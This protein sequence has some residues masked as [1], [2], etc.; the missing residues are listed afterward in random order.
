MNKRSAV[1]ITNPTA[2]GGGVRRQRTVERFCSLMNARGV[3]V[4]VWQTQGPEDA[5]RLADEA[6]RQGCREIIVSG[7]DGTINEAVQALAGTDVRMSVWPTGTANVLGS[8]LGITAN[9][10]RT[11]K[12]IADGPT[13]KMHIGLARSE[14][15]GKSRYFFLMAGIGLDASIVNQVNPELKKRVGKAA[16]W[17]SGLEH[18]A[19]WKPVPFIMEVNGQ[20]LPATFASVGNSPHYGGNLSVTPNARLGNPEFEIC[21]INS[22]NRLKFLQ[23]LPYAVSGLDASAVTGISFVRATNA[24]AVGDGV[25]VQADGEMIGEL[26]MTFEIAPV[27]INIVSSKQL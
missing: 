26:P 14:A 5:T 18:L 25:L 13:R 12:L 19:F 6:A 3:D 4:E 2:G 10:E 8:E 22:R 24:R 9:V 21:T 11:V 17:Y 7:G 27:A 23:L 20:E 1:L 15:T 16:F